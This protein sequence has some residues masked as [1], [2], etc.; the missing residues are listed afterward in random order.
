MNQPFFFSPPRSQDKIDK[1]LFFDFKEG[2]ERSQSE[3]EEIKHTTKEKK[4][5]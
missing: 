3:G 5:I 4:R 1:I 2:G